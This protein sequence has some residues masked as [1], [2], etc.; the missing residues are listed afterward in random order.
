MNHTFVAGISH[1]H[2]GTLQAICICLTFIAYRVKFSRM[3]MRGREAGK[4]GSA[5][6]R[7][8]EVF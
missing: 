6:R 4:I 1:L 3:D 8:A 2:S 5:E 7:N